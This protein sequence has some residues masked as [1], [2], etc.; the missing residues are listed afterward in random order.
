MGENHQ[1]EVKNEGSQRAVDCCD[2]DCQ[3]GRN[4]NTQFRDTSSAKTTSLERHALHVN[5]TKEVSAIQDQ[6]DVRH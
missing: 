3:Y 5:T 2:E 1:Q 6:Q 4:R